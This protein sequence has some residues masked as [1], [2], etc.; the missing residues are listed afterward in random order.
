MVYNSTSGKNGI[1]QNCESLSNLGDAGITGNATLLAKFTGWVND[2]Y[3][4]VAMAILT[5][6]KQWRWDDSNW[7]S[8][9]NQS[10]PVATCTLESGKR[11]YVLPRATNSSDRSTLWKIYKVRVRDTNGDFYDLEPLGT[12]DDES[13]D[14]GRPTKY[15]LL[16]GTIRLS[17]IPLTGSITLTQGLQIWF[18]REF[19]RFTT[20]S[21]TTQP[22]FI[23]AYHYL[24]GLDASATF[25]LPTN[26]ALA[27]SYMTLFNDG[28]EKLKMS[29]AQRNDDPKTTKRLNPKVEDTR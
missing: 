5:V 24:L 12:D 9:S 1:L 11:D 22:Q 4:K 6:D 8:N 17:D 3:A 15:R 14:S 21:T 2:S 29:Y 18:Q 23:S 19:S 20:S 10:K 25:L 27:G 7:G 28:L 26:P 13:A 16:N